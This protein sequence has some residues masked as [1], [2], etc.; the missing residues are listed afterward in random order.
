METLKGKN[1]VLCVT[2]GIAV[3]KAVDV[4]SRLKKLGANV[5]VIMTKNAT[6]FVSPLTFQSLSHTKVI[7]YMFSEI[8]HLDIEHISLAQKADIFVVVPATANIVGKIANGI[9]DNMVTT[10]IM[11]TKAKVLI[12]PAMNTNMYTN[13]IYKKNE[14]NLKELGYLF[15]NPD[16][17]KL[18]C[19]DVGAGK[20]AN[21]EDIVKR[22]EYE[23]LLEEKLKGY[24]ILVTAGPTVEKIDPVRF[25]TNRSTGKMGYAIAKKAKLMG[26]EVV[27]ITGPTNI[28]KPNVDKVVQIESASEMYN[29]VINYKDA[30]VII[31]TA[32][33]SDYKPKEFSNE[34]IKKNDSDLIIQLDR[35]KDILFELGQIKKNQIL[36]G[37]AAETTNVEQY[38]IKKLK[39]KNLDL[40]VA[41]DVSNS[42][43]GFATD[44]NKVIFF[45]K[46]EN[47][48]ELEIMSKD[49]VAVEILNRIVDLLKS[50]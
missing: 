32:A 43:I 13:P 11:A 29:K 10:T 12:A 45:D 3:Y 36:V 19:G 33:V 20:L 49:L 4:V 7:D 1:V 37:F 30:D 38:A 31:M 39:K 15:I 42:E 17:G 50:R 23:L 40:I 28:E 27:L 25:I 24:K 44:Q 26:G 34:K 21:T 6:K 2:G 5:D 22:I 47:K 18:A 41:N 46:D 48:E 16:S 35:N 14:L 9:A 8:Q